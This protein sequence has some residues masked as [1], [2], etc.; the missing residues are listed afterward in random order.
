MAKDGRLRG[1]LMVKKGDVRMAKD[2]RLRMLRRGTSV[3]KPFAR[4]FSRQCSTHVYQANDY[5]SVEVED[6]IF[7][8]AVD[9]SK[10]PVDVMHD[11]ST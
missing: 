9:L 5:G 2:G 7:I 1:I 6:F 8:L 10:L 3:S 11:Q 4:C